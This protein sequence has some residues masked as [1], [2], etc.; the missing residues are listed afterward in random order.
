MTTQN[1][2]GAGGEIGITVFGLMVSDPLPF[3]SGV[4]EKL[5]HPYRETEL[6]IVQPTDNPPN[7]CT[8]T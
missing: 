2:A 7:R 5:T 8:T 6:V 4:Y 3:V 1:S